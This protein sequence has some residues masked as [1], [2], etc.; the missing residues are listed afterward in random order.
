MRPKKRNPQ[1]KNRVTKYQEY[2][3]TGTGQPPSFYCK[4]QKYVRVGGKNLR[5]F[6]N[7]LTTANPALNPRRDRSN[8][9]GRHKLI[10]DLSI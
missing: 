9:D 5:L 10:I 4:M 6:S 8:F 2:D 3:R 1:E 7:F